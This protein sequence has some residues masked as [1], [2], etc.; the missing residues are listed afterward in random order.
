M[1]ALQ[2]LIHGKILIICLLSCLIIVPVKA[3]GQSGGSSQW[4][5][6][7]YRKLFFD[8]HTYEA[9][10]DVALHFDAEN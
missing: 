2:N 8:Y 10:R 7:S 3:Q 1:S 4:F 9:A 6:N 5:L